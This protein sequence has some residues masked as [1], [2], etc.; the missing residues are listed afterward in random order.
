MTHGKHMMLRLAARFKR[1][2]IL[3]LLL[4]LLVTCLPAQTGTRLIVQFQGGATLL[5]LT[6]ALLG[7]K[8]QYGLGD[9]S[10]Q[11]FLVTVPLNLNLNLVVALPGVLAVEID[12]N[13]KAM[14]AVTQGAVPAALYDS[15]PETYYGTTVRQGYLV[16][17]A[18]G[19]IGI[20]SAQSTYHVSGAGTVAIIDTGVDTTHPVLQKVLLPGYDFT[21]NKS[22]ADEKADVTQSTTAVVDQSTTAVVDQSTTAVVDQTEAS[23]LDQPQYADF[24]H[25]T[26]VAGVVHLVAP[27]AMILPLKAFHADGTGYLSDVLRAIYYAVG[28]HA[29]VLNM[30]FSFT[31]PSRDLQ[32]ALTW[33]STNGT[34]N[35]A[36]AGNSGNTN[37]VYPAAYQS[38]VVGVASTS[39][40]DTLSTFSNYGPKL[41]W[42]AA[43]GEGVVTL[44]PYGTYAATWGTSFSTP[45][46]SGAA[47]LLVNMNSLC[48]EAKA[49]Q[50][51]AHAVYLG[52]N[53]GNG[54]LDLNQALRAW[55]SGQ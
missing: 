41:A 13:G 39:N 37:L 35:V 28:H 53:L 4:S 19:I 34:I 23:T 24:G 29:K 20:S 3:P 48:G 26:M 5:Q 46:V 52:T 31:S 32:N 54:R 1:A 47:A 33:A 38:L 36:A 2:V 27:T 55:Q 16:Q 14:D 45:F 18:A 12:Q 22:G 17:P 8:V 9:P 50:S 49:A 25:G 30:S 10:G 15:T 42:V 51:V 44:Y 7:C 6:C 40:N 43:P 21:R 11:L